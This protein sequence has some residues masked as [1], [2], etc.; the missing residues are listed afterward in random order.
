MASFSIKQLDYLQRTAQSK[1]EAADPTL[2]EAAAP[3]LRSLVRITG[4]GRREKF[5]DPRNSRQVRHPTEDFIIGMYASKIPV[6]FRVYGD[7]SRARIEIGTWAG[8]DG[9]DRFARQESTFRAALRSPFSAIDVEAVRSSALPT[10]TAPRSGYAIGIPTVKA[11][12]PADGAL[13]IDRLIRAMSGSRWE[14][15][16]VAAP[17]QEGAISQQR[18]QIIEEMRVVQQEA[19]SAGVPSPLADH[20]SEILKIA[21]YARTAGLAIG[22]W[23]TAVYLLGDDDSYMRLASVWPGIYSGD[24]SLPEP[25]QVLHSPFAAKAAIKWAMPLAPGQPGPG[26]Y[27]HPYQLSTLLTSTQLSAYVHLPQLEVSGFSIRQVSRFD[28]VPQT[29]KSGSER[30]DLAT[31]VQREVLSELP[32]Q[33][34]LDALTK[35]AFVAG[36]TGAGKTTTILHL[37]TTAWKMGVPFL[38]I[39]PAKREYRELLHHPELGPR[40]QVFTL[41]NERVSPFR[42]NPF[43]V[44]SGFP[45]AEHI[46]L[47]RSVFAV[48]FGLWTPLPQILE[49]CLHLAYED[50]GWNITGDFNRLTKDRSDPRVFP[51]LSEL[52]EKIQEVTSAL[53][54]DP[55]ATARIRG[56]LLDRLRSLRSGGKGRL[57]DVRQSVPAELVMERPTVLELESI[58]DDDDKAFIMGLLLIRLVEYRRAAQSPAGVVPNRQLKHLLV[59][60][61]AHR[62]LA[63]VSGKGEE[64][65]SNARA[66]A[67]ES[68][69]NLL[70]EVRSYGQ[71]IVISD[72]VPVKLAPDVIKNTNLKIAHRV[73]D[74]EDRKVLAG[75]MAMSEEQSL[76]LTTLEPGRAAVFSEGDDTPLLAHFPA[77][78]TPRPPKIED[79]ELRSHMDALRNAQFPAT[80]LLRHPGCADTGT[81]GG[82]SCD[83]ARGVAETALFR[84]DFE[85]VFLS[86]LEDGSAL[87]RLWPAIEWHIAAALRPDIDP[88]KLTLCTLAH[89]TEY[90]VTH[91]GAQAGWTYVEMGHMTDALHAL[92]EA[93]NADGARERAL[94][95]L[96]STLLTLHSRKFP[97]FAHC[98]QICSDR[99]LC[100]YRHPVAEVAARPEFSAAWSAANPL[101]QGTEGDVWNVCQRVAEQLIEWA[102]AQR[103]AIRRIGLCFGQTML[104]SSAARTTPANMGSLFESLQRTAEVPLQNLATAADGEPER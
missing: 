33:I 31:V 104:L 87:D 5:S 79:Q 97:P 52:L 40:L 58:G 30:I 91:R 28:V 64:G 12:D 51:T 67:V 101:N 80:L 65:A 53:Q 61:E 102:P 22:A 13:P 50:K 82:A 86:I 78:A 24:E 7:Q 39:E 103:A 62:L 95:A 14:C 71:G 46:D 74:A 25:V 48:S 15:L 75:S 32:Y 69:A 100:L 17:A 37:L 59:F 77:G 45:I 27:H 70:A 57:L 60:E 20:Y 84:R 76:A 38:V 92:Y 8:S 63:N 34:R 99:P 90:L 41:G 88:Q 36:V 3:A 47:L 94:D 81:E 23:H 85:R 49:R 6:A 10:A 73:V 4:L 54:W 89:A 19:Q 72:Q 21:L 29:I 1:P 98:E 16:I 66:K 55:E 2:C 44:Y 43:E 42:L 56:A 35:H 18:N 68:F 96:R 83:A 93:S 11:P 9:G 26:H